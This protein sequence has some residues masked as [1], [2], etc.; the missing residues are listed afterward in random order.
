MK[1]HIFNPDHDI[2]L[3]VNRER[4][5]APRAALRLRRE[6]GYLPMFWAKPGDLVLTDDVATARR[7]WRQLDVESEARLIDRRELAEYARVGS[8]SEVCPW[9]WDVALW[10][11]LSDGGVPSQL[12]PSAMQ[13]QTVRQMSHRAWAA[14][15]LLPRLRTFV[16]TVGESFEIHSADEVARYLKKYGKIVLKEPWS[17]SG[18]GVRYVFDES[19]EHEPMGQIEQP[20]A[21]WV[22]NVVA[23]QG[24]IMVE[25]C[26]DKLMD[27]GMEFASDG[28]GTVRYLGLSLFHTVNGAYVGN[29]V[30]TED[31][32]MEML[33]RLVDGSL[34]VRL[35]SAI[36]SAMG[37][38]LKGCGADCFGVDMMVVR[39]D[40]RTMVHPCVEMNLRRTMGHVALAL[41]RREANLGRVMQ[42]SFD[43]EFRLEINPFSDPSR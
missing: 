37:P 30:E 33:S 41:S 39:G 16:G 7:G 36:C 3:A 11:E 26:Y 9:G 14:N 27:F 20:V 40:G 12:L 29:I 38:W 17:S 21:N 13:L 43:K 8:L 18:R 25:P 2:A 15:H 10:R 22:E 23:R 28:R 5:T 34:I 35:Q 24:S 19:G 31:H 32:K 1:L 6:L 42:I 4:F